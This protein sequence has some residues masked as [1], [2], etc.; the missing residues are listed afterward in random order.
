MSM[1]LSFISIKKVLENCKNLIR[2]DASAVLLIKPQFEADRADIEKA[3]HDMATKALRVLAASYKEIDNIPEKLDSDEI[4]QE[5]VFV[6]LVGMIDPARP[7][8]KDAVALMEK[9]TIYLIA[10]IMIF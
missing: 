1:D 5:M 8:V 7:E 3:N 4:E 9:F 10:D 2:Q 6:G